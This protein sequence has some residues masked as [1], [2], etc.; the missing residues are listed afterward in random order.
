MITHSAAR[1]VGLSDA[2]MGYLRSVQRPNMFGPVPMR[3]YFDADVQRALRD[4]Y[5]DLYE[6]VLTPVQRGRISRERTRV[7][8]SARHDLQMAMLTQLRTRYSETQAQQYLYGDP[9]RRR[10]LLDGDHRRPETL[11]CRE[12][13]HALMQHAH[14]YFAHANPV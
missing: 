1:A 9:L 11:Q 4:K 6:S 8:D 5:A 10:L 13:L 2:D 14:A 3:L 7:F 12:S